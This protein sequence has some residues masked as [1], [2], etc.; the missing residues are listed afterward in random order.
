MATRASWKSTYQERLTTADE[1]V[2]RLQ[3]GQRLILPTLAG[4]PPALVAALGAAARAGTLPKVRISAI[5]AGPDIAT[6]LHDPALAHCFEWDSLFCGGSDRSGVFEGVYDMTPMHFGQM[7]R[8]MARDMAIGAVMTLVSPPDAEGYMSLGISIDYTKSLVDAVELRVVEVNPNVPRVF[9]DCQVH[10]SAVDAIV[11]SDAAIFE[12]PNPPMTPED[13]RI[14]QFIAERIPD[15]ATIQ[16]GY[17]A[18]PS[19]VALSLKDHKHL[20]IHTEMF[21]DNMRYLMEAGVVDNSR[22]SLHPGK[23]LYTFCA[24]T[25]E[26]YEFL[27]ENPEIEGRPVEYT[28]DP[29]VIGRNNNMVSINATVA[30][31]LTGQAC[32]ESI[33]GRQYSGTGGQLDFVRG[34]FLSDG[35]QS[36]LGTYATAKS[37]AV[38][39]IVGGLPPGSVVTAPRADMD[40]VVTEFGVAELRGRSLRERAQALIAIAHPKFHDTLQ[41]E[42]RSR[43]LGPR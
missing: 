4:A 11:E 40:M 27:H 39:C 42:A 22:K 13:E 14:G 3:P 19:A 25:R 17:G 21:V 9:G 28:N 26:T 12:L 7:P 2:S 18:V 10:V 30:V 23:T 5:L 41:A 36:F 24:G 37:G 38:S 43:G 33:G 16:L 35:G 8:I 31:D 34:T 29:S 20:G 15:G 32:S 6:H 1:A